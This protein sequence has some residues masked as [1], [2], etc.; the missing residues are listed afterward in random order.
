MLGEGVDFSMIVYADRQIT[1]EDTAYILDA[2]V[3]AVEERGLVCGG[4][5][6]PI[7]PDDGEG[8]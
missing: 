5:V 4:G 1:E 8:D 6:C 7:D 3:A 2:F